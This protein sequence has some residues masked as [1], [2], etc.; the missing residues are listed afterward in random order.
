MMFVHVYF[1]DNCRVF[2][3][4]E[5]PLCFICC[6][7]ILPCLRCFIFILVNVKDDESYRGQ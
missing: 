2:W 1:G 7:F 6:F 4:K 3:F 5:D